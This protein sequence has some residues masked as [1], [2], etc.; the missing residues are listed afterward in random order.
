MKTFTVQF[1]EHDQADLMTVNKLSEQDFDTLSSGGVRQLCELDTNMGLFVFLDAEDGEGNESYH[2]IRYEEDRE[3]PSDYYSLELKDFY[4]LIAL[5]MS[6]TYIDDN[7]EEDSYGP[8]HHLAHL[9]FHIV[10][11]G[12]DVTP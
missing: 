3:E 2:I 1:H 11:S 5:F 10:D 8:V 6:Q 7:D 4:D 12:K 9:L